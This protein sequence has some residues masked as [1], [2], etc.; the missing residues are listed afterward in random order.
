MNELL[1]MN[2]EQTMSSLEIAE[3]TGKV[4]GNV[5]A[6]IFKMLTELEL[7]ASDFSEPCKMPSGQT[8]IVYDLPRIDKQKSLC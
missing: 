1:Q 6:D 2:N 7:K 4:H 8:A 5:C 3:L